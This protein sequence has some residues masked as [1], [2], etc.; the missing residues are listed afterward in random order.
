M[1]GRDGGSGA[2]EVCLLE[3]GVLAVEGTKHILLLQLP[4][5]LPVSLLC[6]RCAGLQG[7]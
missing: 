6:E 7:P 1:E 4:R 5:P 3:L 2:R